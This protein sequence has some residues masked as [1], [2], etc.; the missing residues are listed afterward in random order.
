M[1]ALRHPDLPSEPD[2]SHLVT[3]DDTPV[4]NVF[5][6]RQMRLLVNTLYDSW[7]PGCPFV[8]MANVG[9]YFSAGE[10]ALV[11]DVLVSLGVNVLPDPMRKENRSY[12]AWRYGKQPD[13]VVEIVSNRVGGELEKAEAYARH[14]I[15]Y[16]VIFDPDHHLGERVLRA[17]VLHGNRY[18]DLLDV[19]WLEGLGLGLRLWQGTYEGMEDLWLRP[20]DREGNLLPLGRERVETERARAKA[21]EDRAEAAEER[22]EAERARAEAEHRR[23]EATEAANERLRARLREL[24]VEG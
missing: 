16:Y 1:E 3:E 22:A 8:A 23:A 2:V 7:D 17:F 6:E 5:S 15:G 24:G 10:P 9:L 20:C 19:S 13:L 11:P 12:L 4:D 21:A 18:L 14:G